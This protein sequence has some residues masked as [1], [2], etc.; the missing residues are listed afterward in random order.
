MRLTNDFL[1]RK[2]IL[3]EQY[4]TNIGIIFYTV[5]PALG[6]HL[7][8]ELVTSIPQNAEINILREYKINIFITLSIIVNFK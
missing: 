8:K 1:P 4:D 2:K 6:P 5:A 7:F 3:L